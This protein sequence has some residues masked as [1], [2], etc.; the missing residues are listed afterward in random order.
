MFILNGVYTEAFGE[1]FRVGEWIVDVL[2][3]PSPTERPKRF[4]DA[5]L[6][7]FGLIIFGFVGRSRRFSKF[8]SMI[9]VKSCSLIIDQFSFFI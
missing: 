6:S 2:D 5:L 9:T 4:R 1:I 3:A 7:P 8:T